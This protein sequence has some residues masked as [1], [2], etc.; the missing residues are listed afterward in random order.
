[1]QI[2]HHEQLCNNNHTSV[3][4]WSGEMP[5]LQLVG[6]RK[7]HRS[8]SKFNNRKSGAAKIIVDLGTRAHASL[9]HNFFNS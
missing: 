9:P 5:Q 3:P 2:A 4:F 7:M 1:M 6:F 8:T